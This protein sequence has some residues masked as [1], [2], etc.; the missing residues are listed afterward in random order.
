MVYI[1]AEERVRG[2]H[3]V[4]AAPTEAS[5]TATHAMPLFRFDTPYAALGLD[6]MRTNNVL[7]P[8]HN[9]FTCPGVV[10]HLASHEGFLAAHAGFPIG[11]SIDLFAPL[12]M[13][14]PSSILLLG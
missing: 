1:K 8:C 12:A 5:R 14:K 10:Q 7:Q 4:G 6:E 9:A 2:M 13:P 3:A 11:T